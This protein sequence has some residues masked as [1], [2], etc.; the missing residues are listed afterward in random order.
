MQ[1]VNATT[2]RGATVV[3]A[4]NATWTYP[5]PVGQGPGAS[6]LAQNVSMCIPSNITIA[7]ACCAAANGTFITEEIA[8]RRQLNASE[9]AAILKAQ[10][11]TRDNANPG[12]GG[13]PTTN[14]TYY[15]GTF[16]TASNATAG[17]GNTVI[18]WCSLPYNP[19]SSTPLGTL[20]RNGFQ[21][22]EYYGN[23]PESVLKW[24]QA[25]NSSVPA[26]EV[27]AGRAGY[28]C[29]IDNAR[30]GGTIDGFTK[31]VR[32][33]NGASSAREHHGAAGLGLVL[34]ATWLLLTSL[35][36]V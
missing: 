34:G 22:G 11:P 31:A 23:T 14:G 18:N 27:T 9:V 20:T 15:T 32:A 33:V 4:D 2:G 29:Y 24:I 35:L 10:Y 19:L 16:V 12:I 5:Y 7:S 36:Q 17:G 21:S 3:V 6:I 13:A 1:L 8:N 30:T 28:V 26:A 25:F